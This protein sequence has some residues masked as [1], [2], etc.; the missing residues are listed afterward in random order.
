MHH[1]TELTREK[2]EEE[3][4]T[5]TESVTDSDDRQSTN[6]VIL[7]EFKPGEPAN[8]HNWP[9]VSPGMGVIV[10]LML[11]GVHADEKDICCCR[12]HLAIH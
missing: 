3:Q 7:V 1:T 12:R 6:D 5:P 9:K 10:Q 8:P 11:I 2:T 4:P